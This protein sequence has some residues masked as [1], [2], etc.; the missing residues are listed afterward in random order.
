MSTGKL[1]TD[2]KDMKKIAL[3]EKCTGPKEL[4]DYFIELLGQFPYHSFLAKW[5]REQLDALLE[6]LPLDQAVC[7]H[8]F[9]EGYACRFQDEIQSQY[10]DVNKVSL[11]VTLLYRHSNAEV[12]G[13]QSTE[14]EPAICKE[15]L[16]VI[17]D[18]ITQD[19][20]SVLHIQ[21]LISKHLEESNCTIKK[22]HEFTDG[23]AGQLTRA[24]TVM[25]TSLVP[26]Q[27]LDTQSSE[28]TLPPPMQRENKMQL[29]PCQTEGDLSSSLQESHTI[30]RKRSL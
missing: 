24:G 30:K 2:E 9:S 17:S 18:D 11:H 29:V 20:D 28:T 10:F 26:W 5:Q 22:M 1:T 3:V 7:I 27:L 6:N 23:C 12:D 8:D 4:F 25:V 15:H 13:V 21:K 16:F 14:E 19:H